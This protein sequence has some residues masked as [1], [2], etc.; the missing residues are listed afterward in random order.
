MP[1]S[2]RTPKRRPSTTDRRFSK[3]N[4]QQA[5]AHLRRYSS[6]L[7]VNWE[8]RDRASRRG[9]P[10]TSERTRTRENEISDISYLLTSYPG[11]V[12]VSWGNAWE[13]GRRTD[14]PAIC[15]KVRWKRPL[16]EVPQDELLPPEL[17]GYRIDVIEVGKLRTHVIDQTDAVLAPGM[18]SEKPR[19]AS[20]TAL[21]QSQGKTFALLSGHATLPIRNGALQLD[22]KGGDEPS[23]I[24]VRDADGPS[25]V[26]LLLLGH[27]GGGRDVDWALAQLQPEAAFNMYHY[28]AG[29]NA[30][31]QL[32]RSKPAE[33]EE[34]SHYSSRRRHR[35]Q[36]RLSHF[37]TA[38]HVFE[39]P[40]GNN[41]TYTNIMEVE[42]M[43][44]T[45]FSVEGDSGSLVVDELQRVVGV[46]LGGSTEHPTSYVLRADVLVQ[47]LESAAGMFFS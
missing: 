24:R 47:S 23:T 6:A 11:V 17:G 14:Q 12:G 10:D 26:G 31:L 1:P 29:D 39:L 13:G 5:L 35:I 44:D 8:R 34:L 40:D 3:K 36:G 41:T 42:W 2:S 33:G 19:L 37:S 7:D 21:A 43:N 45:P 32:R 46:V 28:A 22:Y 30:P 25:C 18:T 15:V 20:M 4:K 9:R 38:P 27:A 16:E